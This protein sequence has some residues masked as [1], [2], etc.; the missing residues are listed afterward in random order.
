MDLP[1]REEREAVWR[2]HLGKVAQ[3]DNIGD[4]ISRLAE[5]SEGFSGAEIE[6]AVHDTLYDN[7]RE[8]EALKLTPDMVLASLS[9]MVPLAKARAFDL[10]KL[11][12]WADANARRASARTKAQDA[13]G[14]QARRL[15]GYAEGG[16]LL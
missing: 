14:P 7:Y 15:E 2:I 13:P 16:L 12:R 4:G 6:Q 1:D 10:E 8:G 3:M 11:G 5:A 9:L